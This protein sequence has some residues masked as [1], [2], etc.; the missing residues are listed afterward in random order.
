VE[1][2][3]QKAP[4]IPSM[5]G[6]TLSGETV[7][8]AKLTRGRPTVLLF[9]FR[10]AARVWS[11]LIPVRTATYWPKSAHIVGLV[12]NSLAKTS[13]A[14]L[15]T[16]ATPLHTAFADDDRVGIYE[17]RRYVTGPWHCHVVLS[18]AGPYWQR[19]TSSMLI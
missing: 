1:A 19:S 6:L 9:G 17:V 10:D 3:L 11:E 8:V 2:T 15:A 16:F 14:N 5:E 7:D 4:A 12:P 13:Q 18:N